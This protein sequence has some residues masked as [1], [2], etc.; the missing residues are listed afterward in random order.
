M[1]QS[2]PTHE[3]SGATE[4]L[5]AQPSEPTIVYVREK[6]HWGRRLLVFIGVMGLLVAAFVGLSAINILP[7]LRNPFATET[8]DRSS[9]VLLQSI[10][11]LSHYVGAQGNF[12][13]LVDLQEN[14][15]YVPDIFFNE[16]TLFVGV[17]SVDA[18]VDFSGIGEESVI[19]SPDGTSVEIKLPAAQLE[20]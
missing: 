16:R 14:K 11:D 12:E 6:P 3:F 9:P 4:Y 15:R 8:T 7:K 5:P 17:G 2:G 1:T 20:K 19:V 13:V 10:Q 18:Y